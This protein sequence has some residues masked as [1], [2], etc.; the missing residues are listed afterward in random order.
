VLLSAKYVSRKHRL[1]LLKLA[2]SRSARV[3]RAIAARGVYRIARVKLAAIW[4]LTDCRDREELLES[5]Y[6]WN[7]SFLW[8]YQSETEDDKFVL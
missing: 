2:Q 6:W 8:R 4:W 5:S 1:F 7:F 3:G